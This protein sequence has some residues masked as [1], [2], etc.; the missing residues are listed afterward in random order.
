MVWG[1]FNSI[2]ILII[3]RPTQKQTTTIRN[4]HFNKTMQNTIKMVSFNLPGITFHS[5]SFSQNQSSLFPTS[6]PNRKSSAGPQL[7]STFPHTL[8]NF[9]IS[10][11]ALILV[12]KTCFPIQLTDSSFCCN[13]IGKKK[14]RKKFGFTKKNKKQNLDL[15]EK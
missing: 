14:N 15:S 10:P 6:Q 13:F 4:N 12:P 7:N 11:T 9:S 5:P 2:F 1:L 3:A 8:Q